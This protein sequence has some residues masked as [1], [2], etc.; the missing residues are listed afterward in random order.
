M[1]GDHPKMCQDNLQLF[2]LMLN[3]QRKLVPAMGIGVGWP[4]LT[5]SEFRLPGSQKLHICRGEYLYSQKLTYSW[6]LKSGDHQLRL[7]VYPSIYRVLY[8]PGGAGF[9]PSTVCTV[10]TSNRSVNSNDV[11]HIAHL[12]LTVTPQSAAVICRT[13][14]H[15]NLFSRR[16]LFG[17]AFAFSIHLTNARLQNSR[18]YSNPSTWNP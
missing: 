3:F 10:K 1:F 18:C 13:A 17:D 9:Q 14:G 2:Q 5:H 12:C 8:I 15:E 7:V 6:W 11:L 4:P 16:H